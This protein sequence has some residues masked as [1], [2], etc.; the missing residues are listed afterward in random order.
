MWLVS[1]G[2]KLIYY[3]P[4]GDILEYWETHIYIYIYYPIISYQRIKVCRVE[5]MDMG[6]FL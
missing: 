2:L 1:L 4:K 3:G 6:R 5:R